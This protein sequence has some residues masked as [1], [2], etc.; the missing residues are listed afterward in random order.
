[1]PNMD[2]IEDRRSDRY[3]HR[4]MIKLERRLYR[5][6]MEA[7]PNVA[8][9]VA[10]LEMELMGPQDGDEFPEFGSLQGIPKLDAYMYHL[11]HVK[12][13]IL[14]Y[15]LEAD[16]MYWL[17]LSVRL[18][19]IDRLCFGPTNDSPPFYKRYAKVSSFMWGHPSQNRAFP[20]G[21]RT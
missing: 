15:E 17:P 16:P 3:Q 2:V 7:H 8:S 12:I 6:G 9:R 13:P 21:R 18:A 10:A 19:Q 4:E 14:E 20:N 1:M 5:D 11:E